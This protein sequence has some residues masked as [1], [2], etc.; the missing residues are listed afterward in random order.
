MND[1]KYLEDEVAPPNKP[2]DIPED[3][4]AQLTAAEIKAE[5]KGRGV[6]FPSKHNKPQ[7]LEQLKACLNLPVVAHIPAKK[8]KRKKKE[9]IQEDEEVEE[10][11]LPWDQ[12]NPARKLLF[13]ELLAGN[14]PLDASA[15]GPAEVFYT[16]HRTLEFQIKG[17]EYG[18]KF[19]SRLRSLRE[20]VA[21]DRK[22]AKDD[23]KALE[24][25][26]KKHPPKRL[27]HRG[28]THWNGSLAQA[29]LKYD[30]SLGKHKTMK[31]HLLRMT[32]PQYQAA[33]SMD[34]FRWKIQQEVGTAKYLYT[35]K[36]DAEQKLKAN[37]EKCHTTKATKKKKK[38]ASPD[39]AIDGN[40]DDDSSWI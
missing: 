6:Y 8:I 14:I 30:I 5:L 16:H 31:P 7:L 39:T 1:D 36:F 29:L 38:E 12:F 27:N 40:D 19:T 20:I 3:V 28:Q 22:R 2:V 11:E 37:L 26:L 15:M 35:L 9:S 32:R 24:I 23:V 13:D 10:K 25:A 33:A 17:M 4:L 21:S 18:S 34:Q